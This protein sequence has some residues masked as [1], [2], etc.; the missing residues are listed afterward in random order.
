MTFSRLSAF[1]L[2]M[3]ALSGCGGRAVLGLNATGIVKA[4]AA[5]PAPVLNPRSGP[6][7]VV[8]IFVATSRK[9]S[10]N[11]SLPYSS[12][13]SP[14]LNF[15]RVDIGIPPS[16]KNGEVEK[17]STKPNLARDFAA[18][19]FQPYDNGQVFID[20]IN[21]ELARRPANQRE[22]FLFIHGYNNN[23][24]D[25]VF[26]TAQIANDFGLP[27]VAVHYSW[28]SAG[29]LG[30]YVYDR[31]SA[32]YGRDGLAETLKLLAKTKAT[33]I[34]LVG[35]S[36]GSYVVMEALREL[37]QTGHR[38]VFNRMSGVMLAA[39]DIDIDV[40]QSQV[41][42]IGQLPRPFTVLVSRADT[43]L[44]ISGRITGGHPRVGDGSSIEILRK[45]GIV[46][47][48]ASDLD[49]G[50]HGV[51]ASS[52]TLMNMARNGQLSS[53]VLDGDETPAGQ[54][55]LADGTSVITGAASLV[56][57]LPARILGA[58]TNIH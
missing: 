44:N 25:S 38:D 8:P 9:R 42:D 55:V 57:Y 51:F 10:D 49:G 13:R 32:I 33:K 22:L 46:V 56:I 27:A 40:F 2:V 16:H 52:P 34:L 24:A 19:T 1:L 20:K 54:A 36:M 45:L 43:A 48:D 31:D 14:T 58:V 4:N 26:R 39:P 28:P 35:H 47:L 15:A 23:F 5:I 41:A 3:L 7:A 17:S 21:A 53:K 18:T 6:K 50:Q 29:S 11:L 37:V 30:L 12:E